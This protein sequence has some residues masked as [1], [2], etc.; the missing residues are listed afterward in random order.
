MHQRPRS[1]QST[2]ASMPGTAHVKTSRRLEQIPGIGPIVATALVAEIGDWKQFRSGRN[3]AAWIGL[4]PKQHSTGGKEQA[5][6]H[7]QAGQS[8]LA[9]AAGRRCHGRYP[10][11]TPA[12]H[13][14][15]LAYANNSAP[16]DK[17][18]GRCACQQDRTDGLGHH[19]HEAR[20]TRSRAAAG[21]MNRRQQ[22]GRQHQLARA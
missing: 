8:L 1:D 18:G 11:R 5:R 22:A 19:G 14:A 10:I 15:A 21:S 16:T 4:V 12:W 6:Q 2:S 9:L 7:H 3:L 13:E 17:G 20:D